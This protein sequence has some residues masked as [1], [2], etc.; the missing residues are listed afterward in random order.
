MEGKREV[1]NPWHAEFSPSTEL[2]MSP[3][4]EYPTLPLDR[5]PIRALWHIDRNID[6]HTITALLISTPPLS[7][8]SLW[9]SA[10]HAL[11]TKND[12]ALVG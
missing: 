12:V 10:P 2:A 8:R 6:I 7:K 1:S 11:A 5:A 9:D 3:I 4:T